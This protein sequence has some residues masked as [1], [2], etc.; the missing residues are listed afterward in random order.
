MFRRLIGTASCSFVCALAFYP[1][2]AQAD[3][4]PTITI[5]SAAGY[6]AWNASGICPGGVCASLSNPSY[7][8]SFGTYWPPIFFAA[9]PGQ[10]EGPSLHLSEVIG[11]A[12]DPEGT[13]LLGDLE[14]PVVYSGVNVTFAPFIAP[15]EGT[16][17]I[18]AVLTGLGTA[19]TA[20]Y[21]LPYGCYPASGTMPYPV[22]VANIDLDIQGYLTFAFGPGLAP[23]VAFAAT[24]T[25]VAEPGTAEF[26][27]TALTIIAVW[28]CR[29]CLFRA[30]K[31]SL[32]A[33]CLSGPATGT[34]Y[35]RT[36]T[37]CRA[38]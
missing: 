12:A 26:L 6:A 27:L 29:Y 21:A 9:Y 16:V 19:C 15:S 7:S 2:V 28:R 30:I 32:K 31:K 37:T 11:A 10:L 24:F 25:P 8:L 36:F 3:S 17:Q 4:I 38:V 18:P 34:T 13:L 14:Y 20:I 5:T 22:V 33:N 23:A 1:A 35:R